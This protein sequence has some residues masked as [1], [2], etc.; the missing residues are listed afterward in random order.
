[1]CVCVIF[2]RVCVCVCVCVL[3]VR[4]N[5]CEHNFDTKIHFPL[6]PFG[7]FAHPHA[8]NGRKQDVEQRRQSGHHC[9][10]HP[11]L[12][13]RRAG[14]NREVGN[15]FFPLGVVFR[16]GSVRIGTQCAKLI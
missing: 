10:E 2:M 4:V 13:R 5:M 1:M 11:A 7:D 15:F 12:Q 6:R 14:G 9:Q 16:L 8:R 3:W